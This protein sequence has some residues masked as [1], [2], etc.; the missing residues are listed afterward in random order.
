MKCG[1]KEIV[2]EIL[3]DAEYII[4][5]HDPLELPEAVELLEEIREN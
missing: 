3:P 5:E 4:D 2:W 1:N